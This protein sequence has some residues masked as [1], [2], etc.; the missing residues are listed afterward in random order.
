M[1]RI[2]ER[3]FPFSFNIFVHHDIIIEHVIQILKAFKRIDIEISIEFKYYVCMKPKHEV[4]YPNV[5]N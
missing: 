4:L 2:S 3:P 5:A 1:Y